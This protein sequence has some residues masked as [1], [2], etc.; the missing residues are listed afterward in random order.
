MRPLIL[1]GKAWRMMFCVASSTARQTFMIMS[2][3]GVSPN[4]LSISRR[5]RRNSGTSL[6]T[7][8]LN[9]NCSPASAGS[10]IFMPLCVPTGL[11][12]AQ[13]KP[14]RVKSSDNSSAF[15]RTTSTVWSTWWAMENAICSA[16]MEAS[17]VAPSM[18]PLMR[19]S[20][21]PSE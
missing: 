14:K 9:K 6:V 2:R 18:V 5:R 4:A 10:T 12:G 3:A 19:A 15:W 13:P 11:P 21:M 16:K 20:V 1:S 8:I 17:L 7:E